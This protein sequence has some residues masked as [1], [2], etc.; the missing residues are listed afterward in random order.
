MKQL[1]FIVIMIAAF[2]AASFGQQSGSN[3]AGSVNILD[4][5]KQVES[6]DKK[7]SLVV[8]YD[9]AAN[10]STISTT[11]VVLGRQDLVQSSDG[12][13]R[14]FRT[15]IPS[16]EVFVRIAF[17]GKIL[18][19]S[20]NEFACRFN[21]YNPRFPTDAE[22]KVVID[23]EELVFK[24]ARSGRSAVSNVEQ[25][26]NTAQLDKTQD[27]MQANTGGITDSA[28]PVYA[29]YVLS[30]ADVDK[31]VHGT[32]VKFLLSK[33]LDVSLLKELKTSLELLLNVTDVH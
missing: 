33:Q 5:K 24:P 2:S 10:R 17:A 13:V 26:Q 19:K 29:I 6:S 9:P 15:S 12:S 3:A 7:K 21:V 30:R 23:G 16:W 18:D 32:K 20:A 25:V 1:L 27:M 8:S 4:I 11:S 14:P 22:L 28:R 31:I